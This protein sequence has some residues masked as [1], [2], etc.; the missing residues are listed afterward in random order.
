MALLSESRTGLQ[1]DLDSLSRYCDKWGLEVNIAK[2]KCVAFRKGGKIGKNDVWVYKNNI[3]E[4]VNQF[5]YLGFLFG[6]SGKFAKSIQNLT[7]QGNRAL[8]SLKQILRI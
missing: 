6:S 1:N 2:T 8:F 4:T 5:K 3:L 7:D